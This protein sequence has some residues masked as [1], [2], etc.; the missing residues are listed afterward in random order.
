MDEEKKEIEQPLSLESCC[1]GASVPASVV[2]QQ[3]VRDY[4]DKHKLTVHYLKELKDGTPRRLWSIQDPSGNPAGYLFTAMGMGGI[5]STKDPWKDTFDFAELNI[6]RTKW[7]E[8]KDKLALEPDTAH[9]KTHN[10]EG[11][12]AV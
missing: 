5:K 11:G 3:V 6:C 4:I 7:Y 2:D 1:A 9:F 10:I 12:K 8:A